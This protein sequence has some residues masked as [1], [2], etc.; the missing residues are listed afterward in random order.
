AR[1]RLRPILMTTLATLA[2]L[3]PL[4]LGLGAGAAL[5][6][7]LAVMVLGGLAFSTAATLFV[8]PAAALL[9]ARLRRPR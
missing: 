7:P 5:H 2:A 1:A 3:L 6:Q 4:V 8:A 9:L